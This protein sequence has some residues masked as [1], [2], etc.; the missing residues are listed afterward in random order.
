MARGIALGLDALG[1]GVPVGGNW[2]DPNNE[3]LCVWAAYQPKG[4]ASFAASLL[5]LSGNG[6]NAGDP[7]GAVTPA[8]D[9]VNGWKFD[10]IDDYLTTTFVPQIDQS[11]TMIVQFTNHPPAG[12][13]KYIAGSRA[14]AVADR[15]YLAPDRGAINNVLYGQGNFLGVIPKLLTGN[16]C[17]SGNQGYRNGIVDGGLIGVYGA[18]P[19][20]P[21]WIGCVSLSGAGTG[22]ID[23]DVQAFALYDCTLT[24]PQ[25]LA[26]ATD[27]AAL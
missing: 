1:V 25:V 23:A 21:V 26:V 16:L 15:F 8:W 4:A 19:T 3:G 20:F 5:D 2:W 12:T 17:V 6:N 13:G 11:Q 24:A 27:M 14:V 22:F 18:I 10:G 7:G 9:A